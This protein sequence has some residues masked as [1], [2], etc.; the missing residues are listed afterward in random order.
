[1]CVCVCVCLG[2]KRPEPEVLQHL[3]LRNYALQSRRVGHGNNFLSCCPPPFRPLLGEALKESEHRVGDAQRVPTQKRAPRPNSQE[4]AE[5]CG[6]YGG[7]PNHPTIFSSRLLLPN[8]P[9]IFSGWSCEHRPLT[10]SPSCS[11]PSAQRFITASAAAPPAL[12]SAGVRG[13]HDRSVVDV[14]AERR[15]GIR[16]DNPLSTHGLFVQHGHTEVRR[17]RVLCS[18]STSRGITTLK[19]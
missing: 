1:M 10:T 13:N 6:I 7:K 5:R 18:H 15:L 11:R 2:Q 9:T 17:L 14:R 12:A 19:M 8:H 3:I 16:R 4:G